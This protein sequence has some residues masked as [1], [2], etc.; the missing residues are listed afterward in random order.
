MEI[1]PQCQAMALVS[2]KPRPNGD[3]IIYGIF[4]DVDAINDFLKSRNWSLPEGSTFIDVAVF[5]MA[6]LDAITAKIDN[7]GAG[8]EDL[9]RQRD[10]ALAAAKELKALLHRVLVATQT[11]MPDSLYEDVHAA[12]YEGE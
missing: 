6:A 11:T 12:V 10:A 4:V 7:V 9:E 5:N 3:R 1:K 8:V 2:R